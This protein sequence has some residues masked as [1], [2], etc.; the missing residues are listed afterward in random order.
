VK[1]AL[2]ASLL[3]GMVSSGLLAQNE[4]YKISGTVVDHATNRPLSKMLVQATP[5]GA[6]QE[7]DAGRFTR[8]DNDGHFAFAN[9]PPANMSC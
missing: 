8:T 1:W 9:L 3:I 7:S 6:S 4:T 2:R 5:V